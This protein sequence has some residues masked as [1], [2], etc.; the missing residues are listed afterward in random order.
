MDDGDID[1]SNPET[2]LCE[3]MGN[4]PPASCSMGSYFDDILNSDADHLACTHTHTCNPPVH[5]L[6]HHTHTC[7]HVHTKILSASND[8]AESPPDA[9]KQRPSGNRAAITKYH[10][11]KKAHTMLL[12]EE[13][14]HLKAMNE[15]LVKKLQ[16]HSA[17]EAKVARL[18]CMLVDIRRRIE[19]EIG[20]FPYQRSVKSNEFVDQGSF[21]GGARVMNSC[22]FRCNDQLYCNLGMQQDRTMTTMVL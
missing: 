19:G 17:L 18:R 6:A 2:Y 8:D 16:G 10:K 21:L 3:A 9:K 11:K 22:D 1:F 13:V 14:A 20:T 12:E 4:D 5:D 15:Q 7:V